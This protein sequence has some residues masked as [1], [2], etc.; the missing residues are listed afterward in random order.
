MEAPVIILF[1]GVLNVR[2]VPARAEENRSSWQNLDHHI[3]IRNV[4]LLIANR[5]PGTGN[6]ATVMC[7]APVTGKFLFH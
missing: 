1:N 4:P 2:T 6:E 7:R 5:V 3:L